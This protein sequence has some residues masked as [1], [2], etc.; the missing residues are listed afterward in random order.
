MRKF[1]LL[2]VVTIF[3][4]AG[5]QDSNSVEPV[6]NPEG[7]LNKSYNVSDAVH[8]ELQ[9]L[10][11]ATAKYHDIKKAFEDGYVDINAVIPNMGHH[12]LNMDFLLDNEFNLTEPEIL[13]YQLHENGRYELVAIE[14]GT[15][16]S[17][18]APPEGFTGSDDVW[19]ANTDAGIWAL[20]AWIWDYNP[21]GVFNGTNPNVP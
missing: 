9:T 20:H 17:N 10:K 2:S 14:Y 11:A 8:S 7:T 13:V 16:L 5:C 21:D 15:P 12:F 4:F 6:D 1:L 3:L 19:V 18:P